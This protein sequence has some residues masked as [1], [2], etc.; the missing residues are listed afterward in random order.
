MMMRF[1]LLALSVLPIGSTLH[2][3][4]WSNIKTSLGFVETP[5]PPHIRVLILHDVENFNLETRGTYSV[6][7]PNRD[8]TVENESNDTFISTRFAGKA[9]EMKAVPDGLKW[10][11][12][13]PGVYQLRIHPEEKGSAV[14]VNGQPY[15]GDIYIYEIDKAT[16]SLSVVNRVTIEDFLKSILADVDQKMHPE[17]MAALI[18]VARTNSYYQALHPKT[19]FW[20]V[21]ATKVGYR[22]DQAPRQMEVANA[23]NQTKNMVLS[24]TGIYEG[25]VT[26]FPAQFGFITSPNPNAKASVISIEEANKMAESGAHAAQ[27]LAKAFPNTSIALI[28]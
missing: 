22:G 1:L 2:A 25:V 27:I 8:M 12:L 10:G 20:D 11:E 26:P 4:L 7:D 9:R 28:R 17:T 13:F 24:A 15:P 3:G 19:G 16:G 5:P 23:L 14:F 18:I 6:Y 21:D